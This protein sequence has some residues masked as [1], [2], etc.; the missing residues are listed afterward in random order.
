MG[1]AHVRE[2]LICGEIGFRNAFELVV[3]GSVSSQHDVQALERSA[4]A[5]LVA[6]LIEAKWRMR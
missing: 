2:D 3:D 6:K 4:V 5:P 1:S